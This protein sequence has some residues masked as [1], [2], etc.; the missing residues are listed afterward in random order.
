MDSSPHTNKKLTLA[1]DIGGSHLKAGVV[2]NS[3]MLAGERRRVETPAGATPEDVVAALVSLVR[4]LGRFDRVSIGFPGVVRDGRVL[5]APNLGTAVWHGYPLAGALER[6]LG[7][8]V[9]MLNDASVQGLG[10][11]S[12]KGI[13]LVITLGTGMGFALFTAGRLA[14]HLE[15]GQ[16]PAWKKKTYDQYIGEAARQKVGDRSWNRRVHRVIASLQTLV[17][18]DILYI[19]G[20]NAR[21]LIPPLPD[22]VV[23]V[24]NE[25]GVTGGVRLWDR[26]LDGMFSEPGPAFDLA[27]PVQVAVPRGGS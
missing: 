24:S 9:R 10:A 8:P 17:G 6:A 15:M 3:G 12:G 21:H 25:T 1:I 27:A 18:Y 26:R 4:P 16:H 2:D 22:H 13:E 19:G 20:G 23:T 14:P 11:I 5:T 7:K